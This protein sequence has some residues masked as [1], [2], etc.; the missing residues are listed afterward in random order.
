MLDIFSDRTV[1]LASHY[2]LTTM[3][4]KIA[5]VKDNK[6]AR[7][8][9]RKDVSVFKNEEMRCVFRSFVW[10][11][12]EG[13]NIDVDL[14]E[15][16]GQLCGVFHQAADSLFVSTVASAR[17]PWISTNVLKLIDERDQF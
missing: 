14:E 6:Q 12:L 2:F 15:K 10:A 13:H 4:V 9:R 8:V 3:K 7:D 1:V 5:V 11:G 16:H 17:R